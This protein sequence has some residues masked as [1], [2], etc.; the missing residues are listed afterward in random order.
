[1]GTRGLGEDPEAGLAEYIVTA[2]ANKDFSTAQSHTF[3]VS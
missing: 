2:G 1:M 3:V